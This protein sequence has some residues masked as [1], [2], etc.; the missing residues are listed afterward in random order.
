MSQAHEIYEEA[1][2]VW[3]PN[4]V[5]TFRG[6]G[7]ELSMG[8]RAGSYFKDL[9][10]NEFINMH[11]NGGVFNL[12]HRNEEVKEALIKGAE[13]VD[14]GNHYFPSQYKNELCSALLNV[15]P[16]NMKYVY[17]LNGGGEANDAAIK[18]ARRATRRNRV[19]ALDCAFHGST[20]IS[21]QAGYENMAEFF[22]MKP[23]PEH[24]THIPY[25]DLNSLEDILKLQDTACVIIETIPATAGFPMPVEGYHKGVEELAHKY[26]AMYIADEVQTGLMRSGQMWC[27][28]KLG[29]TPDIIVTGKGLSGGYYPMSAVIMSEE[30]GAWL[31]EDGFA[32]VSSFNA[33]ELGCIVATKAMEITSRPS[34]QENVEMLTALFAKGLDDMKRKY[35]EWITEIR[36]CGVIMGIKTSHPMGG[37]AL[38][39]SLMRHGVWAVMANFDKSAL[40]FKPGL[41]MK[42]ETAK[43]VLVRLDKAISEMKVALHV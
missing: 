18:F 13:L 21:M 27:V 32:H 26:G 30:A 29:A 41:L 28:S 16:S 39:Q 19:I 11:S 9:D 33:S 40:Q 24:Y 4:K 42:E 2:K 8:E 31:K 10:G 5:D 37:P 6:Y 43:E 22:N 1:Y 12:G 38:M 7:I 14:A 23:N 20:G 3:N 17:M 15:S 25:N 36:Q 35:P 34:T